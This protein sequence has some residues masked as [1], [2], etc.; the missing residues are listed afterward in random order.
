MFNAACATFLLMASICHVLSTSNKS[1]LRVYLVDTW[2]YSGLFLKIEDSQKSTYHISN[3]FCLRSLHIN[4]EITRSFFGNLG[5]YPSLIAFPIM[6]APWLRKHLSTR[7]PKLWLHRAMMTVKRSSKRYPPWL[8]DIQSCLGRQSIL[9]R[10]FF[11]SWNQGFLFWGGW[12][13]GCSLFLFGDSL[14]GLF[15]F[16]ILKNGLDQPC[17]YVLAANEVH[18]QWDL[19]ISPGLL[20][21]MACVYCI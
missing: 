8:Q 12:G 2:W 1:M 13:W 7:P 10:V 19:P 14:D 6:L 18:N 21:N 20:C 4:P 15:L 17:S 5:T 11:V 9:L 3:K 16:M